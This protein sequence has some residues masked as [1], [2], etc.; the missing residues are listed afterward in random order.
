MIIVESEKL[1]NIKLEIILYIP[2]HTNYL[3]YLWTFEQSI[4]QSVSLLN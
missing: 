3:K 2:I 1:D 4:N